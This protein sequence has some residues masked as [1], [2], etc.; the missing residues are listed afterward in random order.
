MKKIVIYGSHLCGDTNALIDYLSQKGIGYEYHDISKELSNLKAFL[1]VRDINP[2]Y[3]AVK[4]AGGV[5]IPT[6]FVEDELIIDFDQEK[7][8]KSLG[9]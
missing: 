8:E 2:M 1:K 3:D 9:L 4:S 5:G 7:L 6:I